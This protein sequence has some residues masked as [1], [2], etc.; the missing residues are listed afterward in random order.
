MKKALLLL[1]T[2]LLSG[3]A[4]AQGGRDLVVL[5]ESPPGFS[6]PVLLDSA[7]VAFRD[8]NDPNGDGNLDMTL[9]R[10]DAMGEIAEIVTFDLVNEQEIWSFPLQTV[11]EALGTNNFRFRGFF[12]FSTD[13]NNVWALFRAPNGGSIATVF[14]D[15][16]SGKSSTNDLMVFPAQRV[17]TLDFNGDEA[18]EL[19]IQNPET[20]TVQVLVGGDAPT[21]VQEEIKAAA[22]RL[23]QNYP[24]PFLDRTTIA[25][26]VE[27][28]GSVT[29]V[30]YDLLGRAVRTLVDQTQP[31]GSY[32]IEWDG[33]DAGGQ[34]VAAG[35]YF[36]RLRVGDAVSSKQA[37]RV[38]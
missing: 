21:A 5:L 3:T 17:A 19:V 25:Y 8:R 30:V 13:P 29:V 16:A 18:V 26:D 27:Q 7:T 4:Y 31:T 20:G 6:L 22:L 2:V 10:D 9:L 36:Y 14:V 15:F 23:F 35:M 11:A 34:P 37:I 32:R 33:R 38:R 28:P 1:L 24:N 12:D